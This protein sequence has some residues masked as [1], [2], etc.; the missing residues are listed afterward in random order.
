MLAGDAM[1]YRVL[2]TDLAECVPRRDAAD[3]WLQL[4]R[5]RQRAQNNQAARER[6]RQW[7]QQRL[8][9]MPGAPELPTVLD[10]ANAPRHIA[11]SGMTIGWRRKPSRD[12]V[13]GAHARGLT[14][15][16]AL[17]AVFADT[18][19]GWS[20]QEQVSAECSAVS[21]RIGASRH[22]PGDRRLHVV[23]HA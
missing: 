1:S 12:L 8:P 11:P 13:A 21:P 4:S 22:R 17:A 2:V 5:Y 3:S 10:A 20:A 6:D 18:I 15:A 23:A 14:P 16:M 9:E 19:G 7:W